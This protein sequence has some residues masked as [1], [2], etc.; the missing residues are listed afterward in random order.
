MQADSSKPTKDVFTL[1]RAEED[2][3]FEE[4]E[5]DGSFPPHSITRRLEAQRGESF[6]LYSLGRQLGHDE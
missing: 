4:F 2:D 6:R 1:E 3:E 5:R